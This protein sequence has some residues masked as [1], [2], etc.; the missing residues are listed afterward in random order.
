MA[1]TYSGSQYMQLLNTLL[2]FIKLIFFFWKY[3]ANLR[4]SLTARPLYG[5]G[6][7]LAT[8]DVAGPYSLQQA[9]LLSLL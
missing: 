8:A 9:S 1:T 2:F 3:K 7:K 5:L 6:F 4:A